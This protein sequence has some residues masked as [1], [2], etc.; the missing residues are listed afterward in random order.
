MGRIL[1][2][3]GNGID[4]FDRRRGLIGGIDQTLLTQRTLSRMPHWRWQKRLTAAFGVGSRQSGLKRLQAGGQKWQTYTVVDGL[5]SNQV[6]S[7]F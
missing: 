4:I 7:L 5:P 3:E 6:P 2:T 1:G